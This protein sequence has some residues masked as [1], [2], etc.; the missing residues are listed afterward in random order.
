MFTR[1]CEKNSRIFVDFFGCKF[2]EFQ[3]GAKKI[4]NFH[5]K[6]NDLP[7]EHEMQNELL[8]VG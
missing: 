5:M 7:G 3:F 2:Y 8:E 4:P 6:M 1:E